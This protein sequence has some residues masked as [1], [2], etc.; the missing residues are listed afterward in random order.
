MAK[1]R[2][3][4]A[5]KSAKP[6]TSAKRS[7]T[8]RATNGSGKALVKKRQPARQ[9]QLPGTEQIRDRVLDTCCEDIGV[10]RDTMNTTRLD[11]QAAIQRA[12]KRMLTSGDKPHKYLHAGVELALVEGVDKLRVRL[13]KDAT[14][15]ATVESEGDESPADGPA[16]DAGE[17]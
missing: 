17:A 4:K 1:A 3:K 7:A 5:G 6:Q 8:R 9:G 12:M 10:A 14:D 16:E 2:K 13:R 11:E 15:T